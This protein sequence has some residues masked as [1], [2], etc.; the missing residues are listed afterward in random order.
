MVYTAADFS[1]LDVDASGFLNTEEL[2]AA[3]EPLSAWDMDGD[4]QVS[5][6]EWNLR[7]DDLETARENQGTIRPGFFGK[8]NYPAQTG[9][10]GRDFVRLDSDGDGFIGREEWNRAGLDRRL[11]GLIAGSSGN[12]SE[13]DWCDYLGAQDSGGRGISRYSAS[14]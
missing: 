8:V 12:I 5:R 1:R 13:S 10:E 14:K 3:E 11:F 4:Q 7:L 6:S 2:S 9:F